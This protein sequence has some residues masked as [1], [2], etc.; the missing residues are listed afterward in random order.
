M[1]PEDYTLDPEDFS[2]TRASDVDLYEWGKP[3]DYSPGDLMLSAAGAKY[4]DRSDAAR[5]EALEL[6]KAS[7][8]KSPE[9]SP[10]QGIAAALLGAIPTIGGY[11]I[12]RSVGD[13]DLPAGIHGFDATKYK[14][15]AYA[16]GLA[17]VELGDRTSKR[18]L[19]NLEEE[20]A[21][22]NSVRESMAKIYLESAEKNEAA[23]I[24]RDNLEFQQQ[25]IAEREGRAQAAA[26]A[27]IS[28]RGAANVDME[29]QLKAEGLG[30]YYDTQ[31]GYPAT[32]QLM[33]PEQRAAYVARQAGVDPT[34]RPIAKPVNI[35]SPEAQKLAG[36][37]E[38][39]QENL[40]L[41]SEIERFPDWMTYKATMAASGLDPNALFARI[42]N[43]KD[44]LARARTGAVINKDEEVVFQRMLLGD[45]SA[46]PQAVA[47][48]LRKI[49]EAEARGAEN[50]IDVYR[51]IND[52]QKLQGLFSDVEDASQ[53]SSP[54][55]KGIDKSDPKYLEIL[56]RKRKEKGL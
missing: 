6:L 23:A 9:I 29:R 47:N 28:A 15:G 48:I 38:F 19:Q 39:V 3:S 8:Q 34:G 45:F 33:T 43:N 14:T 1:P 44:K 37:Y 36:T 17:G 40:R 25:S 21:R 53:A 46:G 24:N 42:L 54:P 11:L 55:A 20:Q 32:V 10:S 5:N 49:S 50:K 27:E 12:G 2:L 35:P 18:Y 31:R 52:P 16:G 41:A 13:P 4:Q 30:R 56:S 7:M 26:L 22:R 51:S